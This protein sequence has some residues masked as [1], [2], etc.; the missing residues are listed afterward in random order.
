MAT[1]RQRFVI[2]CQEQSGFT[3]EQATTLWEQVMPFAGYGFN[4]GHATA[5]ADISYRSAYLKAHFPA[6]F[7]CARLRDYGGFHHPAIYIAEAQRLGIVVRP[8]HVNFSGRK[9]TLTTGETGDWKLETKLAS[10][11][12]PVSSPQS[13]ILWMGLGQVRDLRRSAV[14]AIVAARQERPFANLRDLL[15]RVD[16]QKKEV[17]HL[18]QC[19]ALTG[20]AESRAALLAEAVEVERAGSARQLAFDLGLKTAVQTESLAEQLAW[21]TAVLGWP[22]SANPMA[23]VAS[24]TKDNLPLRH[25]PRRRNQKAAVVGA[26]LPGW[27]GGRGFYFGDG[28]SFEIARLDRALAKSKIKPWL[29]YRL[30]GFWREDAWGGGWFD[31]VAVEPL[32]A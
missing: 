19:G 11:Q 2:G 5:Y 32:S 12:S 14:R 31:V 16:L 25:L 28:D 4:Q 17:V 1:M 8:P 24:Q 23:M 6:Q 7:L 10:A 29:P 26:R 9:F 13:S 15:N 20:L 30:T 18:I 21:E 3:K 22:V 27:T